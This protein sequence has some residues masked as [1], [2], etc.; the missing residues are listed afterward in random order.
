MFRRATTDF[1]G[2]HERHQLFP[3]S[4][5]EISIVSGSR[6]NQSARVS[7]RPFSNSLSQGIRIDLTGFTSFTQRD[8][9]RTADIESIFEGSKGHLVVLTCDPRCKYVDSLNGTRFQTAKI[10]LPKD[11]GQV[12]WGFN[13]IHFR[14]REGQWWVAT[15]KGL[16]R[17]KDSLRFHCEV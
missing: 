7:N 11:L 1:G 14:D 4:I 6:R 12:T 10:D 8:G 9:L 3:F 2:R 16:C 17:Y 5:G 15:T 13:Q